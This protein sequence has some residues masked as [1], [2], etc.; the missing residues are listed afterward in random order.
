MGL[1]PSAAA[2]SKGGMEEG[3]TEEVGG[4]EVPV[5]SPLPRPHRGEAAGRRSG[6]AGAPA[7]FNPARGE[8]P[9]REGRE[10]SRTDSSWL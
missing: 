1:G 10:D 5:P 2:G 4:E 7:L 9:W 3:R 8:P 6:A